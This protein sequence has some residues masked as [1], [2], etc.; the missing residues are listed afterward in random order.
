MRRLARAGAYVL[1]FALGLGVSMWWQ[2][3][4]AERAVSGEFPVRFP[5]VIVVEGRPR[6][7]FAGDLKETQP[8]PAT[9]DGKTIPAKYPNPAF[10]APTTPS[11]DAGWRVLDL[12]DCG[13]SREAHARYRVASNP[14]GPATIEVEAS[15]SE[16]YLNVGRYQVT[17]GTARPLSH[18][19]YFGPGHAMISFWVAA[20][21]TLVFW[22]LLSFGT[23]LWRVWCARENGGKTPSG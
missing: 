15:C 4:R 21:V 14:A 7:I 10:L 8:G 5:L 18:K 20:G 19:Y 6:A 16:D 17:Q 13:S 2:D 23:G 9:P 11:S 12:P 3:R 1:V 22:L